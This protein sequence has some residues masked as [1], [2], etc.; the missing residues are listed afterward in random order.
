[1]A[2]RGWLSTEHVANTD[3]AEAVDAWMQGKEPLA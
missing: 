1:M 2:R 3:S